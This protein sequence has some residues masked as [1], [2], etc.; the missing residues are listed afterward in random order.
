MTHILIT[1]ANR[2]IGRAMAEAALQNGWYVTGTTRGDPL[3]EGVQ[4]IT[5]DVTDFDGLRA[6]FR[7]LA[8]LDILVNNAGIIGPDASSLAMDFAAFAQTLEVNTIAPLAVTRACLPA[9]L[10]CD[11]RPR[12]LS[13][14]SQMSWM[15]YRKSDRIAY[16]A[17]KAALNKTMQGLATDLEDDGIPC[18]LVDPGWV[19]TDMGGASADEDPE[20]VAKGI[21]ELA[22]RLTPQDTGK[23]FRFNG[24]ER[25]F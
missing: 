4:T 21:L 12:I 6:A 13:I 20:V 3:P 2:G 17:S 25:D 11:R 19:R 18:V 8:P 14:S 1:G 24:D 7:G 15:G 16:R 9:L 23:F 22:T 10:K 5:C